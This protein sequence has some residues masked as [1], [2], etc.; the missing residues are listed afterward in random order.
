LFHVTDWEWDN[1]QDIIKSMIKTKLGFNQKIHARKC[2]IKQVSTAQSREFLDQYH[3]Q[4][5]IPSKF[6]LGLYYNNE[7]VMMMTAGK[8]RFNKTK[9]DLEIYRMCSK[10]GVTVVGGASK[11]LAYLRD[12]YNVSSIITYCDRSKS[13]GNGYMQMGFKKI[14]A[15]EPGYFWT[16]GNLVV[17]RYQTQK[18]RLQS[19]LKSYD[20]S[21]SQTENMIAAGYGKF[22]DCGNYIFVYNT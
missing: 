12:Q 8:P 15:T 11:L 2:T 6:Y 4:G 13:V 14:G 19:W 1:K 22:W 10:S 5:Y 18:S 21:K 16:N 20:A 17:S 7:L 3:L 9:Y